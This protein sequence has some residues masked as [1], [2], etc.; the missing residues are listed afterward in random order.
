MAKDCIRNKVTIPWVQAFQNRF[1]RM[2]CEE[3]GE[4][5]SFYSINEPI[6]EADRRSNPF[7]KCLHPR[8]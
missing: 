6:S 1:E 7:G 8:E 4:I 2:S 5:N 3:I